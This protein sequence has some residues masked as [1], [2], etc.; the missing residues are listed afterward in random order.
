MQGMASVRS[1]LLTSG[2]VPH[3]A[4]PTDQALHGHIGSPGPGRAEVLRHVEG[5]RLKVKVDH[6]PAAGP[7]TRSLIDPN[8]IHQQRLG[9][10][11]AGIGTSGPLSPDRD[12]EDQKE[13]V[14]EH[15][16]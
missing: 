7:A 4:R 11:R 8:I 14:V 5:R 2:Q 6:G 3:K 10:R 1:G 13:R 9:K 16:P 15:P 12:V